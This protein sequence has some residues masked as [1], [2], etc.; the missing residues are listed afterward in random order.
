M[1]KF[2]YRAFRCL[3]LYNTLDGF[4]GTKDWVGIE[5]VGSDDKYF[6]S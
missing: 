2:A 6:D 3:G 4:T 1:K 5:S